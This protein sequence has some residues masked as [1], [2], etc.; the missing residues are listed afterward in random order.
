MQICVNLS[1][2]LGFPK[3]LTAKIALVLSVIASSILFISM[4]NVFKSIST[5]LSLSPHWCKTEYVVAHDT[6]GTITSSPLFKSY[7]SDKIS[8]AIAIRFADEPELTIMACFVLKNSANSFSNSSTSKAIVNL[9]LS[10]TL[11]IA[12]ISSSLHES[13]AKG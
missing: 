10:I 1:K 5:N 7:L 2:A 3:R 4:F 13:V 12:L 6:A 9:S 11:L 8:D